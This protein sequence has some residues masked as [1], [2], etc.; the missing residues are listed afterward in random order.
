MKPAVMISTQPK[1]VENILNDKKLWEVRK[2]RPKIEPPF[3]CCIYCT[4]TPKYHHLYDLTPYN[5]GERRYSVVHHNKYSLVAEGFLNGKVIG[6]FICDKIEMVNSKCSDYGI[7]LFYHDC[8]AE[9][10]LTENEVN[11]YF[12]IPDGKDLRVMRGN[13]YAWHI[14]DLKIYDKPKE[15]FE[16]KKPSK[17]PENIDCCACKYWNSWAKDCAEDLRLTRPP[18]SWCYVEDS[19]NIAKI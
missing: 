18:Q 19:R 9:G 2:S 5:N 8:I 4:N 10:C 15:L 17:C 3:K 7:D 1:W 6:E 12:N 14:S 11:K 16:F 13:G